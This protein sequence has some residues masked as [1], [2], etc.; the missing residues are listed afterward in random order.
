MTVSPGHAFTLS[1]GLTAAASALLER[2]LSRSKEWFP[3]EMVPWSLGRDFDPGREHG[4]YGD[5][6]EKPASDLPEGVR[7][8]L[9]V[10]LLTEDNL[11]SY[12][13]VIAQAF[14]DDSA[15]GEWGRRWTAEE[16]R[17]STVIRDWICVTRQL[18]LV[19]L[20]RAR[21][22]QVT[23]GFRVGAHFHNMHDGFVYLTLQELATRIAHHNTG[24]LLD[25]RTGSAI[26]TKV[27]SDENLHFL[28]YRGLVEAAL[29]EDPSE[30]VMAID[31]QVCGFEM[32]GSEIDG[33]ARHA[34]SI[35]AAG[36]YDFRVHHDQILSPVVLR[37]W[38]LESITGLSPDADRA[39][40]HVLKWIG[41]VERV[42]SR[43]AAQSDGD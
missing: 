21:M 26:M 38:K 13:H 23:G 14:G 33:F 1:E 5:D 27:A 30:V 28:F 11:P 9:F 24:Q 18:D 43:L 36:I 20:E 15:I 29:E 31:R 40:L 34:A 22:R 35:A 12:F 16:Q 37:R 32:P 25:D 19:A 41:R 17:H 7:S 10:N 6:G 8:A 4:A 42:A 2:H 3:H 39:R